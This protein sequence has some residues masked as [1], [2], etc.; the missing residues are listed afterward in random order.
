VT[1]ERTRRRTLAAAGG[2]ILS[3]SKRR[4]AYTLTCAGLCVLLAATTIIRAADWVVVLCV[5]AI[6]ILVA[7]YERLREPPHVPGVPILVVATLGLLVNLACMGLLHVGAAES[8]NVRGAYLEVL[9]DAVS[10][11]LVIVAGLVPA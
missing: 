5:M 6:A 7:T 4:D 2:V 3:A 1:F 9:G 11:A 8:L 10:S